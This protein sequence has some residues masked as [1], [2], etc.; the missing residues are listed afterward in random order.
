MDQVDEFI[1][2]GTYYLP[3]QIHHLSSQLGFALETI[4]DISM[5]CGEEAPFRNYSLRQ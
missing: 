2:E 3:S 5:I 4:G 1:N